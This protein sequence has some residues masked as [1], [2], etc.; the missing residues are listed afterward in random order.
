MFHE[1]YIY[2]WD[3]QLDS[4]PRNNHRGCSHQISPTDR[5][6]PTSKLDYRWMEFCTNS[7]TVVFSLRCLS[8][9]FLLNL[10]L[11]LD[12]IGGELSN[13]LRQLVCGHLVLIHEPSEAIFRSINLWGCHLQPAGRKGGRITLGGSVFFAGSRCLTGLS[14]ILAISPNSLGATVRRSQPHRPKT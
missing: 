8:R 3:L 4:Y 11:E 6:T 5:T 12:G 14:F 1:L 7:I 2:F 13:T 9:E 10:T